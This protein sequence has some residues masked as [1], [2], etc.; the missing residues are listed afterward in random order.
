MRKGLSSLAWI[1]SLL[2]TGRGGGSWGEELEKVALLR[3]LH[4]TA[5]EASGGVGDRSL[6]FTKANS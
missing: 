2:F 4:I 6:F 5:N 3:G 1:V